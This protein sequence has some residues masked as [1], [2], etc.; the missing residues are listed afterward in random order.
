MNQIR[1]RSSGALFLLWLAGSGLRLSILAVPPVLAFIIL[2]FKLTGTEVGILNG[3]PVALFAIAAVPG[4]L[5]IARIGAV[6]ALILGLLIAAAGSALRGAAP[7]TTALFVATAVMGAG[8]AIMQPSLPPTVR[9]WVPK[10]IGFA[11]AVYTNGLLVGEILPVAL[12]I[13]LIL[14]LFNG[15]WR[16]ALVFWSVPLV[17]IAA[18]IQTFQPKSK[19]IRR[20]PAQRSWMPDWR[21][22]LLWKVSLVMGAANQLYFCANAFLPGYLLGAGR[23]DLIA[24][25]LAALNAGQLPAS[26]LL[27]VFASRWERKIWP[28]IVAGVLMLIGIF[29]VVATA[30]IWTTASAALIGFACAGVLTLVLALPPLLVAPHDVPRMSAGVFSIGYS[31]AMLSSVIAGL[32]WDA[33]GKPAFAFLPIAMFVLPM[34][35]VIPLIDF[36]QR[37]R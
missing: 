33:A 15:S 4:S 18:I 24:P 23:T 2:D 20:S 9:Q 36:S 13:P 29:G 27:L 6:P 14:P 19:M 1:S 25:V 35:F 32:T 10:K 30:N 16:A 5:L 31:I 21:D 22:P 3:I 8:I 17:I 28:F 34:I 7:G 26:F 37:G 12:A 11:T